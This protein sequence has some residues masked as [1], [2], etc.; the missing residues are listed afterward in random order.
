M[1]GTPGV[2]SFSSS[3][4]TA[5]RSPRGVWRGARGAGRVLPGL[6]RLDPVR[7]ALR[8][9]QGLAHVLLEPLDRDRPDPDQGLV[10][11]V[12]LGRVGSAA[13]VDLGAK[14]RRQLEPA[15]D[16]RP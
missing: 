1:S 3:W 4:P 15:L 10:D 9:A 11:Q 5:A 13:P 6:V 2:V 16:L 14:R 7:V 8:L 12:L